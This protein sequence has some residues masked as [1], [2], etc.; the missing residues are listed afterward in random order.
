MILAA[1]FVNEENIQVNPPHPSPFPRGGEGGVRG[2]YLGDDWKRGRR[3]SM[4][5]QKG[6]TL[7]EGVIVFCLIGIVVAIAAPKFQKMTRNADLKAAARDIMGD[8][9]Y[10]R[11]RALSG[12]ATLGSRMYRIS[13]NPTGQ[14]YQLKQC[15][16]QGSPCNGWSNIQVK[17]FTG[18]GNDI[19]FDAGHTNP[20]DYNFQT[21]GTITNGTIVLQNNLGSTATITVLTAGRIYVQ[22][23]LHY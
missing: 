14:S 7:L 18:F 20:T 4:R 11:E 5:S 3:E 1:Q 15:T 6:F 2:R 12:D 22:Y 13:L 10:L 9:S 19:S 16:N 17:N 23:A 21:R 8:F